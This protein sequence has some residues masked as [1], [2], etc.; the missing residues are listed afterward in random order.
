MWLLVAAT[1]ILG[2]GCGSGGQD[3][4][5]ERKPDDGSPAESNVLPWPEGTTTTG[6]VEVIKLEGPIEVSLAGLLIKP[7]AEL[8][9]LADE[10][11]L[12]IKY[13][14]DLH[15]QGRLPFFLLPQVRL[16][17]A[18]PV[19]RQATYSAQHG[20]SVPPY[21]SENRKDTELALHLARYGDVEA[22][23]QLVDPTDIDALKR[24][25][26]MRLEINF[27][28]D[29]TRLVA[30]MLHKA[31]YH[32]LAGNLD[33]AKQLI[34]LHQ[35]LDQLLA[36]KI[37]SSPLGIELLS[38]GRTILAEAARAWRANNKGD[39]ADQAEAVVKKWGEVPAMT[40]PWQP[41]I[42]RGRAE[43]VFGTK[44]QGKALVAPA[45]LRVLDLLGLAVPDDGVE[46]V[47]GT[48][49]SSNR[50]A[51][52]LILYRA[53]ED[54]FY[55]RPEALTHV[56]MESLNTPCGPPGNE[57]PRAGSLWRTHDVGR[58]AFDVALVRNNPAVGAMVR[59]RG[60]K[61]AQQPKADGVFLARN[62]GAVDLDRSFEQSRRRVALQHRA[63]RITLEARSALDQVQSPITALPPSR[64]T[65]ERAPHHDVLTRLTLSYDNRQKGHV[66]LAKL[67][68]PLWSVAGPAYIQGGDG[69]NPLL[70]AWEDDQTCYV[71]RLPNRKE[72]QV[73]LEVYSRG[74]SQPRPE[75]RGGE[76]VDHPDLDFAARA[77]AVRAHDQEERRVRFA[78][79]SPRTRIPRELEHIKLG[80]TR[81]EVQRMLPPD[82]KAYKRS[83]SQGIL[84]TMTGE[85]PRSGG[86]VAREFCARLDA[87]GRVV[88]IRA[89]YHSGSPTGLAQLVASLEKR[90]GAPENTPGPW[91]QSWADLPARK[92]G[93]VLRRWQDDMTLLTCQQDG[94]GIEL[95]LRD[96]PLAHADGVPL[97]PLAY[98]PRGPENC[99]L[100]TTKEALFAQWKVGMPVLADGAV[101]LAP[102]RSSPF[103]ALLVW[104]DN[105]RVAQ[106]IARH[107]SKGR[108]DPAQAGKAV[109]EA[110]AQEARMLG[111]PWR[112]D[113]SEEGALQSWTTQEDTTRV[114]I[115][116]QQ[117]N[118]GSRLV[119]TEWRDL[120]GPK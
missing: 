28:V 59:V 17:L 19:F 15:K 33:D 78:N 117:R 2:S 70:L 26:A 44:G 113:F 18:V 13:F 103:D 40:L 92:P 32:V 98:L 104:F 111:L 109:A 43:L 51:E 112:Q 61:T 88:E 115:F 85:T 34:G 105:E 80:M 56:V 4:N 79:Q 93:P 94:F 49:D 7:R 99:E 77:Q 23:R 110:W 27:P 82:F 37:R 74:K 1:G 60:A 6:G 35:Q 84:V 69:P 50:L 106:I 36:G 96:C 71:L 22:A 24:I 16:P 81:A 12:R 53:R 73:S 39:L 75:A 42:S 116:W 83:L 46:S 107:R 86:A 38:R 65:L 25:E 68:G 52:I 21:L 120:S 62:F 118:D 101:V 102:N 119:F 87:S 64:M 89:R 41:G 100:G 5:A 29:W 54:E 14:E 95:C 31:Q 30:L 10:T 57:A 58:A 108:L 66:P 47:L 8:A 11:V 114:R 20:F 3:P 48:V 63:N 90:C 55:P 45:P 67:A 91:A 9:A 72:D 97:P 76:W